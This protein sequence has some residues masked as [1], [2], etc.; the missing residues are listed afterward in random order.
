MGCSAT[1]RKRVRTLSF[2]ASGLSGPAALLLFWLRLF[3][4]RYNAKDFKR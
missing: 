3:P 1:R 4:N 2:R